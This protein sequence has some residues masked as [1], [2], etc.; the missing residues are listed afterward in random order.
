METDW[1][2]IALPEGGSWNHAVLAFPLDATPIGMKIGVTMTC[3]LAIGSVTA[4]TAT[5]A[6][7]AMVNERAEG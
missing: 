5:S 2:T 4:A 6:M 1:Q 3:D 7:A